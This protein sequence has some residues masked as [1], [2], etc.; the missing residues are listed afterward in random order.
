MYNEER[1]SKFISEISA[2][3]VKVYTSL[4]N[5]FERFE[6][7][8]DKDLCEFTTEEVHTVL[9]DRFVATTTSLK[10]LFTHLKKYVRWCSKQG[11][12]VGNGVLDFDPLK[13]PPTQ[14]IKSCMVGSPDQLQEV[15]DKGFAPVG[16][17]TMDCVYRCY[18]WLCFMGIPKN[19]VLD[20]KISD[21]DTSESRVCFDGMDYVIPTQATKTF[22]IASTAKGFNYSHPHY[23]D[24]TMYME[25]V[26]GDMLFRG[27]R[28]AKLSN[29]TIH[30]IVKAH[31]ASAGLNFNY[32]LIARSGLF[33]QNN[34]IENISG[35]SSL[36]AQWVEKEVEI[37][38]AKNPKSDFAK[39]NKSY[40]KKAIQK[41]Y[42]D[43]LFY[44]RSSSK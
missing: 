13:A 39:K 19:K 8:E 33:F 36:L 30:E 28:S 4:F 7:S 34:Y 42:E 31:F 26:P 40:L 6:E 25:R 5:S 29:A 12:P 41:E 11:Y 2:N 37:K 16:D 35:T 27:V 21:V 43:W 32:D 10:S 1:K 17:Q 22:Q 18:V 44:F 15:L 23:P 20:V 14:K 24:K 9:E 38:L 3:S